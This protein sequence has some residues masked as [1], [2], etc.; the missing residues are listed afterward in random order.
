MLR[1]QFP[2]S[3]CALVITEADEVILVEQWRRLHSVD[4]LEL[5]GGVIHPDEE[6]MSAACREFGE[7]TGLGVSALDF[8]MTLDMDFSMSIHRTHV[9]Y[10]RL[11]PNA[12]GGHSDGEVKSVRSMP[13]GAALGMIANGGITH[14]PTV[15][16]LYW[17]AGIRR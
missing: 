2:E 8:V 11:D 6:P 14:A 10:G 15:A 17:H 1:I 16:A 3:A 4:T 13:I 5:P 12:V 7:E 9:F